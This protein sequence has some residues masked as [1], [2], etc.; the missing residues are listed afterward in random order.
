MF[1]EFGG[2]VEHFWAEETVK[3]GGGVCLGV[4]H[5]VARDGGVFLVME[6]G[7]THW[8]LEDAP[9]QHRRLGVRLFC[10]LH[11]RL[12]AAE[13]DWTFGALEKLHQTVVVHVSAEVL[14]VRKHFATYLQ[15]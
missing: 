9:V 5:Q 14:G 2:G 8:T 10:V 1:S 15:K 6:Y 7:I 11:D 12:L 13:G 4:F 3:A